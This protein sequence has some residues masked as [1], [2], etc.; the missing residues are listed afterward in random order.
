[1]GADVPCNKE[2]LGR[3]CNA[4]VSARLTAHVEGYVRKQGTLAQHV[5]RLLE[6]V[7]WTNK[8]S[9]HSTTCSFAEQLTMKHMYV[10]EALVSW[11]KAK[12][13]CTVEHYEHC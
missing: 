2:W 4:S 5:V 13:R 1:M 8:I 10:L 12:E 9:N 3:L 7:W 6:H 11:P